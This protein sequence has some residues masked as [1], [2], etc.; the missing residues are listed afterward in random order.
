[1]DALALADPLALGAAALRRLRD[2]EAG[3]ARAVSLAK[4]AAGKGATIDGFVVEAAAVMD[5]NGDLV[6][7]GQHEAGLVVFPGAVA[8]AGQP[9]PDVGTVEPVTVSLEVRAHVRALNDPAGA[10]SL[11]R[12]SALRCA[13]LA[14]LGGWCPEGATECLQFERGAYL[15]RFGLGAN[16]HRT[17]R[18]VEAET[19]VSHAKGAARIWWVDRYT[20]RSVLT[21]LGDDS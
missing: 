10:D 20:L 12:L 2:G 8:P 14:R 6:I 9:T 1:M 15:G 16:D 5:R 7:G 21:V 18:L 13:A 17:G 4:R 19:G 11:D 3:L